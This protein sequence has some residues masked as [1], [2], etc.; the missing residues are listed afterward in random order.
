M[1]EPRQRLGDVD[2]LLERVHAEV[3]LTDVG[4]RSPESHAQGDRATVR[5]PD[6]AARRLGREHGDGVRVDRSG[7]AQVL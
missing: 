6:D 1:R 4:L 7:I 3:R 5:V 2:H